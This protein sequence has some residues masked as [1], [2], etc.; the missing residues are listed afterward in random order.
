MSS[1]YREEE[2]W[3]E[4]GKMGARMGEERREDDNTVWYWSALSMLQGYEEYFT[5]ASF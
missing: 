3:S 1:L 5:S 4:R 2:Q